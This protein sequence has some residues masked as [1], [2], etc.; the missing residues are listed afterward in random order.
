MAMEITFTEGFK[1]YFSNTSWLLAEKIIRMFVAL[2]VCVCVARYLEPERFGLLSYAGSFVGLF[3]ALSSMGLDGI[4]VRELVITPE[5]QHELLGTAFVL[6]IFGSVLVLGI[7]AIAVRFTHNDRFTNLLIFIMAAG[8]VFRSFNVIDFYFQSRVLSKY[9]VFILLFQLIISSILK[10]LFIVI[11]APLLWFAVVALID[12]VILASGLIV[13]YFYKRQQVWKWRARRVVGK[14][15][16]KDSWPLI[17]SGVVIAIYMKIDQVMIKE[18]LDTEAV[19]NYAAAVRL[20]EAWY[21]LPMVICNSLFPAIINAKQKS[22]SLYYK[23]L[24][25]LYNVMAWISIGIALPM[26]F[27]SDFIINL[28]FGEMYLQAAP[29]LAIHMWAGVFVFLGVTSGKHLIIENL[30]KISFVRTLF[31][32]I[33]NV[34]MNIVLI[35]SYGIKGAAFATLISYL[36]ATFSL[37]M[38][39]HGRKVGL[40][41]LKSFFPFFEQKVK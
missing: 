26:T 21:F 41:M 18:M 35:P 1:R 6:K 12:G 13:M 2:F 39:S 37:F 34:I 17:L 38:F 33:A 40:M 5:K 15:L 19:G 28:L 7:L 32:A 10:L 27:F 24:Q 4:V 22:E 20:S 16:L 30:T 31:G 14:T 36:I 3:A 23:R 29:V 8:L 9:V 11:A 25:S